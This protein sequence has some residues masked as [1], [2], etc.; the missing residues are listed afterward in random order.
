M[1][2]SNPFCATR[3]RELSKRVRQSSAMLA[4]S[5]SERKEE[6]DGQMLSRRLKDEKNERWKRA[7]PILARPHVLRTQRT[8]M[9]LRSL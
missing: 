9:A 6:S 4:V 8:T 2:P 3:T 1:T 7:K 5:S